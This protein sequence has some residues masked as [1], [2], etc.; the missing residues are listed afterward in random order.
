VSGSGIS[1]AICKS[2]SCSRQITT[3]APH[4]SVFYRPDALPSTTQPTA[5]KHWRQSTEGLSRIKLGLNILRE[6][7]RCS[8]RH[9]LCQLSTGMAPLTAEDRC[10][11]VDRVFWCTLYF[12]RQFQNMLSLNYYAEFSICFMYTFWIYDDC[13]QC[14]VRFG[15]KTVG[16]VPL[17]TAPFLCYYSIQPSTGVELSR[18]RPIVAAT[19]LSLW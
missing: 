8:W 17:P 9:K 18:D 11:K 7:Y 3:P 12:S 2:A 6:N 5:S 14:N 19:F 10:F 16:V 4:H 15:K 1:W 13:V